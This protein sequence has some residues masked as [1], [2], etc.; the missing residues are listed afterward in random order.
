LELS[1]SL[2]SLERLLLIIR[3]LKQIQLSR[4]TQE[5]PI[6]SEG[7]WLI[8]DRLIRFTQLKTWEI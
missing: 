4:R 5:V 6:F 3:Y 1:Q 7:I 8:M 2:C